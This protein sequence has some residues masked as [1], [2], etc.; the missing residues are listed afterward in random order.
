MLGPSV[1]AERVVFPLTAQRRVAALTR[2]R[3]LTLFNGVRVPTRTPA[4]GE[5]GG[6]G[7]QRPPFKV[8][9]QAFF[10]KLAGFGAAPQGLAVE[11]RDVKKQPVSFW[12]RLLFYCSDTYVR[13]KVSYFL[14]N[15]REMMLGGRGGREW[16]FSSP[17]KC[18]CMVPACNA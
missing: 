6:F 15:K 17:G 8:F 3:H 9:G 10:K 12:D 5:C 11:E 14:R 16:P 7:G 13:L 1:R 4:H 2:S 18:F